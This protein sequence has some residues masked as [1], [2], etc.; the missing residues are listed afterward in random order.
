MKYY[1][2]F[3]NVKSRAC[4]VVGAG[5]VGVRKARGLAACGAGVTVISETFPDG[6]DGLQDGITCVQKRYETSDMEGCFLVFAATDNA[7]LNHRIKTD[8]LK[9]GALCNVADDPAVSDFILPS[10]VDRGDLTIAVSTSGASPAMAR[11]IKKELGEAYGPE[12]ETVLR[13][14]AGVRR[15]LLAEGH[16]PEAHKRLFYSLI[17]KN[18]LELI[19]SGKEKEI[20]TILGSVLGSDF[21]FQDLI[22]SKE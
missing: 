3:M 12:Y 9:K 20:N 7:E 18:I 22:S 2:V 21:N 17:E 13:L 10:T 5:P 15:R 1:P 8:A 16:D 19:R 4:L 6:F 14:L 11:T